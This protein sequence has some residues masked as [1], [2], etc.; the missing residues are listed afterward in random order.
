MILVFA[1]VVL[2]SMIF[3]TQALLPTFLTH[4]QNLGDD[5]RAWNL[6]MDAG[7]R[8]K[9]RGNPYLPRMQDKL[10]YGA[11]TAGLAVALLPNGSVRR[12]GCSPDLV[13]AAL[14]PPKVEP[15]LGLNV[16]DPQEAL[17]AAVAAAAATVSSTASRT[18]VTNAPATAGDVA[19]AAEGARS[20]SSALALRKPNGPT[21][22]GQNISLDDSQDE[23]EVD[24]AN[25]G[26]IEDDFDGSAE[27]RLRRRL[28]PEPSE[29]PSLQAV[30]RGGG[31]TGG[32]SKGSGKGVKVIQ[33]DA[34]T[35]ADLVVVHCREMLLED[36]RESSL[37]QANQKNSEYV[38][39]V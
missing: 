29:Q 26:R 14:R 25:V 7:G 30:Q 34:P 6:A 33:A 21:P 2:N 38:H 22:I 9:W 31:R 3:Q 32:G 24:L 35:G 15:M 5:Q 13:A 11:T 36:G 37:T 28:F 27:I 12:T 39:F 20:A 18:A 16:A 1:V 17:E 19:A 8:V 10:M 4:L 23:G